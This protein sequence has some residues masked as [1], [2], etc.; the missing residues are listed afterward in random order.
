M[1]AHAMRGALCAVLLGLA[2]GG[3]GADRP[4]EPAERTAGE[5]PAP[6]PTGRTVETTGKQATA[7]DAV[8]D[9]VLAAV[10]RARPRLAVTAAEHE[11]RDGREYY[12]VGGTLAD[13]SELELDLMKDAGG[14]QVVEI[15]RDIG[16]A[17]VP[18]PVRSA[19]PPGWQPG[20]VIESDQ[21]DGVVIYE[22]FGSGP[23]GEEVKREVRWQNGAAELLED[24]WMH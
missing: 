18:E 3:C 6:L 8:P 14:W 4:P 15:Q 16:F 22:F 23:Q 2:A 17:A 12:D 9:D 20:R 7:L 11:V 19:L 5:P 21:G 13:G 1:P 24:E 10:R